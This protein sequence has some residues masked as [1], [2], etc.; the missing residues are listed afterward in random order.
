MTRSTEQ[1]AQGRC[2]RSGV[3]AGR[4]E[5]PCASSS[6][7]KDLRAIAR[8]GIAA[9]SVLA[10]RIE[11]GSRISPAASGFP[12]CTSSSAR[13]TV[14]MIV[15]GSSSPNRWRRMS[16]ARRLASTDAA[17][18]PS[19]SQAAD[20]AV[21]KRRGQ[22][23]PRAQ[24]RLGIGQDRL[25][26]PPGLR[27]VSHPHALACEV[28]PDG[29]RPGVMRSNRR[30]ADLE[31]AIEMTLRRRNVPQF[32]LDRRGSAAPGP[33][34]GDRAR[35]SLGRSAAPP[36]TS[37]APPPT[38]R[39]SARR[40]RDSQARTRCRGRRARGSP[41]GSPAP[42]RA[43]P[44][45]RCAGRRD[46]DRSPCCSGTSRAP[47]GPSGAPPVRSGALPTA[48][49]APPRDDPSSAAGRRGIL[50]R[51]RAQ[52]DEPRNRSRMQRPPCG[53]AIRQRRSHRVHGGPDRGRSCCSPCAH[54]LLR[55][56]YSWISSASSSDAPASSNRP[57]SSTRYRRPR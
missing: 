51:A 47:D 1:R 28:R 53:T 30:D 3:G 21:P 38:A 29:E 56:A 15:R 18:S 22:R 17:T 54:P 8:C 55:A 43:T 9:A 39:R 34:T 52:D 12:S 36:S 26:L 11:S 45:P 14:A 6:E 7:A 19:C 27:A 32:V 33:S 24:R 42:L 16:I 10:A 5:A 25:E 57:S 49:A 31:R 41:A 4:L 48:A 35:A 44:A 23:M 50:S 40:R 20:K 13:F 2:R 46:R 37:S